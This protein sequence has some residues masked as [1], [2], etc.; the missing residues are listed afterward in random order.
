MRNQTATAAI[1]IA[2]VVLSFIGTVLILAYFQDTIIFKLADTQ[3]QRDQSAQISSSPNTSTELSNEHQAD[4]QGIFNLQREYYECAT[5][6]EPS[7]QN[8]VLTDKI[9]IDFFISKLSPEERRKQQLV[10]VISYYKLKTLDDSEIQGY[11]GYVLVKTSDFKNKEKVIKYTERLHEGQ[12]APPLIGIDAEGGP[13]KRFDWHEFTSLS[14]IT[15]LDTPEFCEHLEKDI[16]FFQDTGLNWAVAPV[17]DLPYTEN[18]WIYNRTISMDK[19]EIIDV[20]GNYINCMSQA[21]IFTTI[22]HF[23]G[24]G[25]TEVDSHF[26][27][28]EIDHVKDKWSENEGLVFY[29]LMR[30]NENQDSL[31]GLHGILT[32][33]KLIGQGNLTD[34]V[35][36]RDV[37]SQNGNQNRPGNKPF[38]PSVMVGHLKYPKI[39]DET[40]TFSNGWLDDVVRA[41]L[42]YDGLIVSDDIGMLSPKDTEQRDSYINDALAAGMDL[43]LFRL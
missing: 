27:I 19:D 31:S 30:G 42:H 29:N 9:S 41:D 12:I 13:V 21:G 36:T 16:D 3:H 26:D 7:W 34:F 6:K 2:T 33:K 37:I 10:P 28:P 20:A 40:A 17:V 8:C 11:G 15:D 43:V 14:E 18:D 24:H 1:K 5:A 25:D 39:F 32:M 38:S 22:K 23:P 4:Y 35:S